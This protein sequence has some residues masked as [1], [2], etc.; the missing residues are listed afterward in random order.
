MTRKKTAQAFLIFH[1]V[2]C[3][4]HV[5]HQE[6]SLDRGLDYFGF[7]I[8]S[9]LTVYRRE[10]RWLNFPE[11]I[12]RFW[13]FFF[14]FFKVLITKSTRG[15]GFGL[16]FFSYPRPRQCLICGGGRGGRCEKNIYQSGIRSGGGMKRGE[17][18]CGVG[19]GGACVSRDA[20]VEVRG[21][22]GS[23]RSVLYGTLLL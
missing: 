6:S 22:R 5:K 12:F 15:V 2:T 17:A 18:S 16:R 3:F 11:G 9:N 23:E 7:F 19:G 10:E 8:C 20:R 14:F 4:R 1:C 13:V 21:V